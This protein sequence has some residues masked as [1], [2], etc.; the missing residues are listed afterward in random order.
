MDNQPRTPSF[1]VQR[2]TKL[3]HNLLQAVIIPVVLALVF[4]LFLNETNKWPY[5]ILITIIAL[6]LGYAFRVNKKGD[7]P[8]A[9]RMTIFCC[10]DRAVG[11]CD[12]RLFHFKG[13]LYSPALHY[14]DHCVVF[15]LSHNGRNN[16]HLYCAVGVTHFCDFYFPCLVCAK[17]AQ[18]A[19]F[20]GIYYRPKHCDQ[21]FP[22]ARFEYALPPNSFVRSQ[23]EKTAPAIDSGDRSP[24]YITAAIWTACWIIC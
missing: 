2:Q 12:H 17:L 18:C 16:V 8:Q 24:G 14:C 23:P 11:G 19:Y 10:P 9:A 21:L 22:F 20:C 6:F 5:T 15:Y 7:Y 1:S 13:R 4:V 3:L